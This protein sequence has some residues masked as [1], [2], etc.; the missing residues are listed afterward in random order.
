M[1]WSYDGKYIGKI[2]DHKVSVYE[3]PEMKMLEDSSKNPTSINIRNV[4]KF[5]WSS[6]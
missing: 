1:K 6:K 5:F 3:L 2:D 4:Q